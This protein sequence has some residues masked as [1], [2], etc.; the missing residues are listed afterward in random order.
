MPDCQ[1]GCGTKLTAMNPFIPL[2]SLLNLRCRVLTK[3][4]VA[5][6]KTVVIQELML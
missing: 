5:A 2:M 1:T 4:R 3:D 6:D